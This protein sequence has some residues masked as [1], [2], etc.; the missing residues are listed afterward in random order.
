MVF[1][2]PLILPKL[3]LEFVFL[4]ILPYRHNNTNRPITFLIFGNLWMTTLTVATRGGLLAIAQTM[5]IIAEL[6][7]LHPDIQVKIRKVT[8]K[9]DKDRHTALWNLKDSGFFTSQVEDVLMAGKADFAIHS[10][11]DLPTDQRNGLTIAAVCNRNFVEDCIVAKKSVNSLMQLD[12][13]AKIGTS[14]LRRIV[15][16]KRIRKDIQTYP[17][18]GNVQT[19]LNKLDSGEFD[20]VVLARAGLERLKMADKISF[21]FN[22][23]EFIPAPA[24]GALAVQ[25]RIDDKKTRELIASLDNKNMRIATFAERIILTQ[26]QCGCHAPVGAYAEILTDTI[27]ISAFLSDKEGNNFIHRNISGPVENS[28]SMAEKIAQ[29]ILNSGGREILQSI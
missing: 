12:S 9:G 11:K 7:K 20:A 18:R 1:K 17:I 21:T 2:I 4:R 15:Q 6:Q 8:T 23:A 27:K 13:M 22:P 10:F 16:L 24:Q 3:S 28:Q 19:R 25:T 29:E 14:S 5:L 26:L